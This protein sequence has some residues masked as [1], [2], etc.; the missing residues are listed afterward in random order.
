MPASADEMIRQAVE[1]AGWL[2]PYV[3][4]YTLHVLL[5]PKGGILKIDVISGGSD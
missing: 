5:T 2:I 4:T 1:V 3:V